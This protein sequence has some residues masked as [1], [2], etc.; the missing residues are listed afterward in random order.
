MAI[1]AGDIDAARRALNLNADDFAAARDMARR[2]A[3]KYVA[4]NMDTPGFR[5]QRGA[6]FNPEFVSKY[7]GFVLPR[8]VK[9]DQVTD[10][11]DTELV[12]KNVIISLLRDDAQLILLFI[13]KLIQTCSGGV[14]A[15]YAIHSIG[16]ALLGIPSYDAVFQVKLADFDTDDT[17][18]DSTYGSSDA[19][20]TSGT[21]TTA[22]GSEVSFDEIAGRP[23]PVS[24]V[25]GVS[26]GLVGEHQDTEPEYE[27]EPEYAGLPISEELSE[28]FL[29]SSHKDIEQFCRYIGSIANGRQRVYALLT[30]VVGF[31]SAEIGES[32]HPDFA[33]APSVNLICSKTIRGVVGSGQA[34][35]AI[36][37]MS[38][39]ENGQERVCLELAGHIVQNLVGCC[40]YS[41][42]LK[43]DYERLLWEPH[44]G[45]TFYD[46]ANLPMSMEFT[47]PADGRRVTL[48]EIRIK[49]TDNVKHPICSVPE[50]PITITGIGIAN[51]QREA[52]AT[53]FMQDMVATVQECAADAAKRVSPW[54]I[55]DGLTFDHLIVSAVKSAL[56]LHFILDHLD[57]DP[58]SAARSLHFSDVL[59]RI[60]LKNPASVNV[61]NYWHPK[62]KNP[63]ETIFDTTYLKRHID[64]AELTALH[65]ELAAYLTTI[66]TEAARVPPAPRLRP[67]PV[68][69]P[70]PLD[71]DV[72]RRSRQA[73]Y[74]RRQELQRNHDETAHRLALGSI[75]ENGEPA[76]MYSSEDP[77]IDDVP[78]ALSV[79]TPEEVL[80]RTKS[81]QGMPATE[82]DLR[83]HELDQNAQASAAQPGVALERSPSVSSNWSGW[84]GLTGLLDP[85]PTTPPANPPGSNVLSF[86]PS[87]PLPD[88]KPKKRTGLSRGRPASKHQAQAPSEG[89]KKQTKNKRKKNKPKTKRRAAN[90]KNKKAQQGAG[91]VSGHKRAKVFRN[92]T[93]KSN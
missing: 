36:F 31:L 7:S 91:R 20:V 78:S 75:P 35:M 21:V 61:G 18:S 34:L 40:L 26:R 52:G 54:R 41:K 58:A 88:A 79:T 33:N 47:N 49:F 77:W 74:L 57:R 27:P 62:P 68:Q 55:D 72:L 11:L 69:P 51:A 46:T 65:G 14:T 13:L 83:W 3:G 10:D 5:S 12:C 84:S 6:V 4:A 71:I 82:P 86:N 32:G 48:E 15:G 30:S 87:G 67:A 19:S 17:G 42:W 38:S 93:R 81:V 70:A 73:R 1:V 53:M 39:L 44:N 66:T 90:K 9:P 16:S 50:V 8:Q 76:A 85:D 80:Q 28:F 59:K 24:R 22:D 29:E 60:V 45:Y 37:L 2:I 89:G 43:K 63:L 92:K 56:K 23:L 25:R 64:P